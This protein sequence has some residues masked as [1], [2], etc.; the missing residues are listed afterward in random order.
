MSSGNTGKGGCSLEG[1][2]RVSGWRWQIISPVVEAYET[3][4]VIF[5]LGSLEALQCFHAFP[6]FVITVT[7]DSRAA[8]FLFL[9]ALFL[10]IDSALFSGKRTWVLWQWHVLAWTGKVYSPKETSWKHLYFF[11]IYAMQE[12]RYWLW[13]TLHIIL[14]FP[15]STAKIL[16]SAWKKWNISEEEFHMSGTLC[17]SLLWRTSPF[18]TRILILPLSCINLLWSHQESWSMKLRLWRM[19]LNLITGLTSV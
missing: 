17:C 9:P 7:S 19:L 6:C 10:C 14:F 11:I 15:G 16:S 5:S 1:R 13:W 8:V 18:L 3:D 4:P 2:R 12:S